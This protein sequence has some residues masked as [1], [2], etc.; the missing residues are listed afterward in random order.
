MIT[1]SE[2]LKKLA[3]KT[4]IEYQKVTSTNYFYL[5]LALKVKGAGKLPDDNTPWIPEYVNR[6]KD[7]IENKLKL[8]H[9]DKYRYNTY[10]PFKLPATLEA[11]QNWLL[12]QSKIAKKK[13]KEEE[14]KK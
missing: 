7:T 8:D 11:K 2:W 5:C 3:T 14:E 12:E 10:Q 6:L 13:E 4:L 9:L 1:Y